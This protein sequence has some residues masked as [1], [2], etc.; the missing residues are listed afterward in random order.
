MDALNIEH[1]KDTPQI[2]L[3]KDKDILEISGNSIPEDAQSFYEPVLAWID[4]Y[5]NEPNAKTNFIF[6]LE[7]F[8]TA[9]SKL[10]LD[11][12]FKLKSMHD[13]G[14]EVLVKWYHEEDDMDMLLAAQ[15]YVEITD[16]K[17]EF[18]ETEF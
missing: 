3:D 5:S 6:K 7:Y 8:N 12:L 17:F 2:T 1:T 16:L 14:N 11:I 10:I 13:K 18:L 9:S 15:T 4:N